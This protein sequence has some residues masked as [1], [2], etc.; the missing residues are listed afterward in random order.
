MEQFPRP[1]VDT[2]PEY[3]QSPRSPLIQNSI[4]GV[5]SSLPTQYNS[6]QQQ[7]KQPVSLLSLAPGL[8]R[9][10]GYLQDK[11]TLE[12]ISIDVTGSVVHK[13]GRVNLVFAGLGG[14]GEHENAS[15]EIECG[16]KFTVKFVSRESVMCECDNI[17]VIQ[18]AQVMLVER[19]VIELEVESDNVVHIEG[20]L[21]WN[22]PLV[23]EA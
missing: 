20:S 13:E 11:S 22:D 14:L 18:V 6:T 8:C 2:A 23:A 10:S 19:I 3:M 16:N 7:A 17:E 12:K 21:S 9:F 15:M 5:R 4:S 1:T